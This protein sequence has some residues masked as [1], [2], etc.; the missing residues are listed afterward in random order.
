MF[1]FKRKLAKFH[2]GIV[3]KYYKNRTKG[4]KSIFFKSNIMNVLSA[5][6]INKN[7]KN[8]KLRIYLTNVKF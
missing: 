6:D 5:Q 7:F 2:L 3:K 4:L 1:V 8:Q